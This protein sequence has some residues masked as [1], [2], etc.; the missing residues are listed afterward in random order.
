MYHVGYGVKSDV[1]SEVLIECP[2]A[3]W[4]YRL[5]FEHGDLF[6]LRLLLLLV[7]GWNDEDGRILKQHQRA[8]MI[9]HGEGSVAG[10]GAMQSQKVMQSQIK[11]EGNGIMR[12]STD[13]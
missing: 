11:V 13:H 4:P 3:P 10:P 6:R 8:Q 7:V 12:V 5:I 1:G 9:E 2:P